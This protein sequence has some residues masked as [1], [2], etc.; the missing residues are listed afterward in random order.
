MRLSVEDVIDVLQ[1]AKSGGLFAGQV[2]SQ[3]ALDW[4]LKHG[5]VR[6]TLDG[7]SG[8]LGLGK[9]RLADFVEEQS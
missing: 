4:C 3:P 7:A 5:L 9:L 8:F 2:G 6:Q 1:D